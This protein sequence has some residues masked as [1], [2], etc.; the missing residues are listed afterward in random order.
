MK[1][2]QEF[3]GSIYYQN[4]NKLQKPK[5]ISSSQSEP[6]NFRS[7]YMSPTMSY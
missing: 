6:L 4:G 3:D 1:S 2:Q 5:H 7:C